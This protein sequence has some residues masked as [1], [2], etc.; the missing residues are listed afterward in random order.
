MTGKLL[1]D[2]T[3]FDTNFISS[4]VLLHETMQQDFPGASSRTVGY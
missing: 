1:H 2:N 3:P 4:D